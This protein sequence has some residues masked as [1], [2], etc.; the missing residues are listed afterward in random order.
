V[1]HPETRDETAVQK[2]L[3]KS[4]STLVF[5]VAYRF[6][7]SLFAAWKIELTEHLKNRPLRSSAKIRILDERQIIHL[8][9]SV[10]L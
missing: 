5:S 2:K 6:E 3:S 1:D 7:N 10:R 8:H 4:G 9:F